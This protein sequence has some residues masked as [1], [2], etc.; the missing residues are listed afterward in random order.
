MSR[1]ESIN[2]IFKQNSADAIAGNESALSKIELAAEQLIQLG[3]LNKLAC[4]HFR[5]CAQIKAGIFKSDLE[6]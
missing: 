1:L 6:K 5:E 4:R 2:L 3:R